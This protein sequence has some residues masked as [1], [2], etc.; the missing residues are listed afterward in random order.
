MVIDLIDQLLEVL[1]GRK[2][3]LKL[4][5]L[6]L[7]A[8]WRCEWSGRRAQ[9]RYVVSTRFYLKGWQERLN[10]VLEEEEEHLGHSPDVFT[11]EQDVLHLRLRTLILELLDRHLEE[12]IQVYVKLAHFALVDCLQRIGFAVDLHCPRS[13]SH[14]TLTLV[15]R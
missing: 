3:Y 10:R 4:L 15:R 1:P 9:R 7:Y 11:F 2:F 6:L 14:E 13:G 5:L 12:H 8:D